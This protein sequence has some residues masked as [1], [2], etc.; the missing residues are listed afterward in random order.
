MVD[1]SRLSAA[2]KKLLELQKRGKLGESRSGSNF[3]KS[4]EPS[5]V[6][7]AQEQIWN[8]EQTA[9]KLAPLYNESITIHRHG[10]C[11]K[12]IVEASIAEIIRRH[13]IWRTTFEATDSHPIQV[14]HPAPAKFEIPY[15]DLRE[16]PESERATAALTLATQD[17]THS[18]DLSRGPLLRFRLVTLSEIE[19]KLFLTAHQIIV[20]GITVFDVFPLELATLYEA[21][22]A[23]KPSPLAEVSAQASDFASWQRTSF[24]EKEIGQQ[25][26]YWHNQF[27]DDVPVLQWPRTRPLRQT[28]RGAIYPFSLSKQLT[29]SV[30]NVAREQGST[31]FSVLLSTLAAL[32]HKYTGQMQIVI[33]TLSPSGRK[34]VAFQKLPG[35][36]LNPV[37]LKADLS[38]NPPFQ[39]LLGQM[40]R[41]ILEA[42]TNDGVTLE[43]IAQR[44]RMKVDPARHPF[45]TIALSVAP[46][47][48]KLPGGWEMTYMDVE[49]GGARWDLYVEMSDRVEGMLGRAQYNPDLFSPAEIEKF[50]EDF[51][52]L[53]AACISNLESPVLDI[54]V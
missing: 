2:K 30:R 46:E 31:V 45:F 18:F 13:E 35:Y 10:H 34:Q 26:D 25:L 49:S 24:T 40:R 29:T 12:A 15:D 6:S 14:I 50:V 23:G 47:A 22:A 52:K 27:H 51:R 44:L 54:P 33:G 43:M 32:L 9:G 36:F 28:Y 38:R 7:F 37:P 1:E 48:V 41:V 19:H 8:L 5:P 20:D 21:Y 17:A 39:K 42:I 16:L 3:R 4:G 11:D 53:L